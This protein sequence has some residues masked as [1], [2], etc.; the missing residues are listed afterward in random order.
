MMPL[1]KRVFIWL[2][3]LTLGGLSSA[4]CQTRDLNYLLFNYY[5]NNT[6][7]S[8]IITIDSLKQFSLFKLNSQLKKGNVN[9]IKEPQDYNQYSLYS[10][11]LKK[12]K[13]LYFSGQISYARINETNRK[14]CS[15]YNYNSNYPYTVF[16][17]IAGD[18]HKNN[19][20]LSSSIIKPN[21]RK[22]I[23]A[24]IKLSY[25]FTTGAKQKDP[26]PLT[27]ENKISITPAVVYHFSEK[28]SLGAALKISKG[29]ETTAQDFFK[30]HSTEQ[31]FA[32]TGLGSLT[33]GGFRKRY[34]QGNSL[35]PELLYNK[36][37][38]NG[39]FTCT[40]FFEKEQKNT[41]VRWNDKPAA[42]TTIN[43][44]AT[45]AIGA[46]FFLYKNQNTKLHLVK[47]NSFYIT[48]DG[49]SFLSKG[50][51]ET[52]RVSFENT[53]L[54]PYHTD[55]SLN[56]NI[57]YKLVHKKNN[58][59]KSTISGYLGYNNSMMKY[60]G[61][62]NNK[63]TFTSIKANIFY[64]NFIFHKKNTAIGFH[65]HAAY[66]Y[67]ISNELILKTSY[68]SSFYAQKMFNYYISKTIGYGLG[69]KCLSQIKDKTY[70]LALSY[71]NDSVA[72]SLNISRNLFRISF[73]YFM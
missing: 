67:P 64:E 55:Y 69:L 36:K 27:R 33:S 2:F 41:K 68:S 12:L 26:R 45:N 47:F 40:F 9:N 19:L 32:F 50:I 54:L 5:K 14:W 66:K 73:S 63:I 61:G 24:A 38:T 7:N 58:L 44:Y 29:L 30:A 35:R 59:S 72:D 60:S 17:T 49:K 8:C 56:A 15:N 18:W 31:V 13:Q 25:L 48:G 46:N 28:N 6:E 37:I 21:I 3:F 11:G 34:I 53:A 51:N 16:D 20:Y 10:E 71:N 57:L 1:K 4:K 62:I 43:S 42:E 22:K 65:M 23:S 52:T 70:Q 39:R